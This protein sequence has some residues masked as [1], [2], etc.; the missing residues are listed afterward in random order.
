MPKH[1]KGYKRSLMRIAACC[2]WFRVYSD[3]KKGEFFLSVF[4]ETI[5]N[6]VAGI[7]K[8]FASFATFVPFSLLNET[9]NSDVIL[10]P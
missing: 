10:F 3:T 6:V 1:G 9:A 4:L 8:C 5:V 2:T 7:S